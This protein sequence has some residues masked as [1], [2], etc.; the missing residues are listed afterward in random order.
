MLASNRW[1][2]GLGVGAAAIVVASVAVA[3]LFGDDEQSFPEDTP[4]GRRA[5]VPA[6]RARS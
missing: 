2:V 6:G 3:V 5:D 4:R 1:L